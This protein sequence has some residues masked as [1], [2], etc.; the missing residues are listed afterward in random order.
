MERKKMSES[1]LELM[2]KD[3]EPVDRK[4]CKAEF[5][6]P[7]PENLGMPMQRTWVSKDE[8]KEMFPDV[9]QNYTP[10]DCQVKL[11]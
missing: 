5:D 10:C 1:F 4:A 7:N 9:K 3:W 11:D 6:L 2:P 8:A